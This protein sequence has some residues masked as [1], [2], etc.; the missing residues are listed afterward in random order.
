MQYLE[1]TWTAIAT[2]LRWLEGQLPQAVEPDA[3]PLLKLSLE[4]AATGWR[5][6]ADEAAAHLKHSGITLRDHTLGTYTATYNSK[7]YLLK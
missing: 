4:V 5:R 7:R 1:G 3:L 6:V 2:D